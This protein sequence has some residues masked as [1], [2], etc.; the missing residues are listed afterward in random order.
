MRLVC[1]SF[2]VHGLPPI[3]AFI[4]VFAVSINIDGGGAG[5]ARVHAH[6]DRCFP[7][8]C[9]PIHPFT[10]SP[11]HPCRQAGRRADVGR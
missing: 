1:F 7:A 2:G 6:G 10:H 9:T 3:G 11:I 5:S 8:W 4:N